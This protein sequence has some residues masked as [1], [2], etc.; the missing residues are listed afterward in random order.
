MLD[1]YFKYPFLSF[2]SPIFYQIT[3]PHSRDIEVA[4]MEGGQM[5][6][7]TML[8]GNRAPF[9]VTVQAREIRITYVSVSGNNTMGFNMNFN[10]TDIRK[11]LA[12]LCYLFCF[13]CQS[14]F[15]LCPNF[16]YC[17]ILSVLIKQFVQAPFILAF[18]F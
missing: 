6:K 3:D 18:P 5:M 7:E 10:I 11:E 9:N 12:L 15:F 8:C 13:T 14:F 4:T 16:L 2:L 17:N 1:V